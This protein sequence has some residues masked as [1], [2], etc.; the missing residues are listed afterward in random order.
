MHHGIIT[1]ALYFVG[2]GLGSASELG[3]AS[4]ELPKTK[5]YVCPVYVGK[6]AHTVDILYQ[7]EI[8]VARSNGDHSC[9]ILSNQ[10]TPVWEAHNPNPICT[11]VNNPCCPP[12]DDGRL[13]GHV[14]CEFEDPAE[15]TVM[16]TIWDYDLISSN[17]WLGEV[18][19]TFEGPSTQTFTMTDKSKVLQSGD[20][21]E[22]TVSVEVY[23]GEP[24]ASYSWG[25]SVITDPNGIARALASATPECYDAQGKR[26]MA[27]ETCACA[28]DPTCFFYPQA[29]YLAGHPECARWYELP[30]HQGGLSPAGGFSPLDGER[31]FRG[32]A[33]PGAASLVAATPYALHGSVP[34]WGL[35][36]GL[37]LVA[38]AAARRRLSH[39]TA[40]LATG[41]ARLML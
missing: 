26:D 25:F 1:A 5:Y 8:P 13:L 9:M 40:V 22:I 32:V 29:S 27:L 7:L 16:L 35:V 19:V 39:G 21:T 20:D 6:F 31:N 11:S 15:A 36:V 14:C 12:D 33:P 17:K 18:D 38:T 41:D 3:S 30:V 4:G 24:P 28:D 34:V 23:K 10:K 2:L 37:A